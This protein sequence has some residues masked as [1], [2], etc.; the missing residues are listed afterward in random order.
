MYVIAHGGVGTSNKL[1]ERVMK[2]IEAGVREDVFQTVIHVVSAMEDDP[3]FNAGTGSRIK[4]DGTI[5]MDA[6]VMFKGEVGAVAALEN[7]KNPVQVAGELHE[8]PYVMLAGKGALDFAR[9]RG[10]EYYDPTTR[11]REEEL[12]NMHAKLEQHEELHKIYMGVTGSDTVGCVAYDGDDY[13]AAVSTGGTSFC[14]KG[15]VGDS[16]LI[17]CGFY[18]GEHGAVV[19]TGKGEDLIKTL[20]A[21]RCYNKILKLGAQ[22]ACDELIKEHRYSSSI[23]VIAMGEKGMG[24]ASNKQM[25]IASLVR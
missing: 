6:A 8:T 12:K 7:V 25:S 16:P 23:G 10:Y 2:A 18:A 9:S 13:A 4:L 3:V 15:R 19:T 11:E 1:D 5:Q 14:I 17:G 20:S 24:Y 22:G 21:Y